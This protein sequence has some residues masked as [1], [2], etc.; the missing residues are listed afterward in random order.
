MSMLPKKK[1]RFVHIGFPKCA[2][3]AWQYDFFAKHPQILFL[4]VGCA[5]GKKPYYEQYI[6]DDIQV[7]VEHHL[8][9]QKELVYNAESVRSAFEKYFVVAAADDSVFAVGL[10]SEFLCFNYAADIDVTLKAKRILD[11][12]GRDTKIVMFIRNQYEFIESM[13]S[14]YL[15]SGFPYNFEKYLRLTY[16]FKERNFL[17]DI[18]YFNIYQHYCK[19]FGDKNVLIIPFEK[20]RTEPKTVQKEVCNYLGIEFVDL[21]LKAYNVRIPIDSY[22]F[23]RQENERRRHNFG[24]TIWE[25]THNHRLANYYRK[26]IEIPLPDKAL[27]DFK[28]KRNI[29]G[30]ARKRYDRPSGIPQRLVNWLSKSMPRS[31]GMKLRQIIRKKT[32]SIA[33][34]NQNNPRGFGI[35]EPF[36]QLFFKMFAH[37]NQQLRKRTGLC[38]ERYNYPMPIDSE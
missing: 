17:T 14:E 8:R 1:T 13:Y 36:F 10:S 21:I 18:Q 35:P 23:V 15:R 20:F 16:A 26:H 27:A 38:L 3:T 29:L 24:N 5:K 32:D 30:R 37:N 6:D 12:F 34:A 7:A 33:L 22:E 19:L 2:S 28:I 11:I 31:V 9:Y 25:G 4:G